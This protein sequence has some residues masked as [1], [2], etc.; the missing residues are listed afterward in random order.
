MNEMTTD[1]DFP[2][3]DGDVTY[4]VTFGVSISQHPYHIY[5]ESINPQ[6]KSLP[7]KF[8]LLIEDKQFKSDVFKF[9]PEFSNSLSAAVALKCEKENINFLD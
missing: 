5:V 7:V 2:S 4:R 8:D 9:D 6:Y 3:E 1:F